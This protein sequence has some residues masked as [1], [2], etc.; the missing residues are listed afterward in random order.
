MMLATFDLC[1]TCAR[2]CKRAG[3]PWARLECPSSLGTGRT[4][5]EYRVVNMTD[6]E[7]LA[8]VAFA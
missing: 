6:E 5:D 1:V 2:D 8:R 7:I 4:Y 3:P